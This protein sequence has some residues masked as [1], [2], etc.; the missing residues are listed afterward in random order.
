MKAIYEPKGM[1]GKEV[2]QWLCDGNR[3][4]GILQE[5]MGK[6]WVQVIKDHLLA[7]VLARLWTGTIS[8]I[9]LR[10]SPKYVKYTPKGKPLFL[11]IEEANESD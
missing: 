1:A 5:K 7:N 10:W 11:T 9:D 6:V 4:L 8:L 2:S 3:P